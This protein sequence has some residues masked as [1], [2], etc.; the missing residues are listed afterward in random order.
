MKQHYSF[1]SKCFCAIFLAM[2]INIVSVKQALAQTQVATLKHGDNISAFYGTNA[3]IEAYDAAE[4]G[5]VI[6][7]SSGVYTIDSINKGITLRGAGIVTDTIAGTSSTVITSNLT[8]NIANDD[9]SLTIEGVLFHANTFTAHRLTNPTFIKCYFN[10]FVTCNDSIN[11][12]T[13]S[14]FI[15]CRFGSLNLESQGSVDAN[16]I[17]CVIWSVTNHGTGMNVYNSYVYLDKTDFTMSAYNCIVIGHHIYNGAWWIGHVGMN[18][19]SYA[20]N[21]IGIDGGLEASYKDNC[22]EYSS[23]TEVFESYTG[24]DIFYFTEP[25]F[26]KEEIASSCLGTDGKQV[27]IYGGMSP[28]SA[29]PYYM[30]IKRCTVGERTT[31]DGHFSVD[32]EVVTEE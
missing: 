6:T 15:N 5:D 2:I 18:S 25:L 13:S 16:F 4:T 10:S 32:I 22:W 19:S 8:A 12:M 3:L 23:Y 21:C 1:M 26:L 9:T 27:G 31:D 28:Y 7:L 24:N 11:P 29:R 20:I 14:R 30:T 17:N